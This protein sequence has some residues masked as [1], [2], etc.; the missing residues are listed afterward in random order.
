MAGSALFT[1]ADL[2]EM[3]AFNE[4]NLPDTAVV[5]L[6]VS[7]DVPGG[8]STTYS[9]S[10]GST[11]TLSCR[12][13]HPTQADL[14]RFAAG[15]IN[16][17]PSC[18]V[19]FAAGTDIDPTSRLNL[20]GTMRTTAGSVGWARTVDVIGDAGPESVQMSAR[21]PCVDL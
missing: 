18:V 8:Q 9:P 6:P 13:S 15:Q 3:R 19:T 17:K 2:A 5:M 21:Y 20:T 10:A 4:A 12:V 16:V 7:V 1:A 11:R 14:E